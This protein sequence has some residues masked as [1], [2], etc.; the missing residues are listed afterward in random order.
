MRR[1]SVLAMLAAMMPTALA[2]ASFDCSSARSADERAICSHRTLND[3]DV[4]M[5]LLYG[6][7]LRL[8]PMGTRDT[9]R[10]DQARWLDQRRA[11]AANAACLRASYDRRIAALQAVIDTRVYRHGPF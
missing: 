3:R 2:A 7:D 5:A 10:R 6:L 8:V 4:R 11:C 1:G 9:M